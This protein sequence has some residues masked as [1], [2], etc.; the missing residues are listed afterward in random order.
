MRHRLLVIG[1]AVGV[2]LVS[3]VLVGLLV[4]TN[5]DYGRERVRRMA[6][7]AV[8]GAA[9]H[10]VVRLGRV[11]G[12]LLQG[13]TIANVSIRDSAGAPFLV[14]DSASLTYGLRALLLKRLD[15][16]NVRLVRPLIVLDRP[17]GDS[18]LWNYK[19]IFR[20]DTPK[21]LRDTTKRRF[22]DWIVFRD[23]TVVD[24]HMIIRSPWR[25]K[26]EYTGA[27]RDTAIV[28]AL[29]GK[30]R[31]KVVRRDDGFQKIVEFR[32]FTG[33]IP[34][35]RLKHPDTH[36]RRLEIAKL[37]TVALPFNPPAAVVNN[38]RGALDFT[39]DS[40]WF[41][42]VQATLP[43]SR[44]AA[45]GRYVF[46]TNEFDLLLRGEPVS[47]ADVRWVMPQVSSRGSG[48]LDFR[49]RWR[50]DT[51][52]YIAQKANLQVD[53]ARLGG[54]F[55][56]SLVGDSL[57]FHNTDVRFS[58]LDTH[59]IEQL[60]PAVRIPRHGTLTGTAKLDGP[61]GLMR[62]DGDVAFDDARY[63][64]SRV[65]AVGHVGTTGTGVRFRDLDVTLDPVRVAMANVFVRDFPLAGTM[66]GSAR[67]N[68]ATDARLDV[69]ADL[70]HDDNG[71][72]SRIAGNA[73]LRLGSR[74]WL[75][76]DARLMPLSL[77]EV[78]KFAPAAG[79]RGTAAGPV[80]ATG[81]LRNLRLDAQ[82]ALADGGRLDARGTVDLASAQ[83]GYD[84]TAQMRVFNA[85]SVTAR[86]P[87]TSLTATAFARG[88]G[89]DP[90]TMRAAVGASLATSTI[91][92]VAIDSAHVRAAIAG[93][94]LQVDSATVS[95][96]H[97]VVDLDGTFGLAAGRTGTLR[98]RASVDSLAALN[99]FFPVADTSTVAPR[100]RGYSR[101]VAQARADSAAVARATEIERLATG[102]AGPRLGPVPP[103][104]A[105]I[106]RDSTAGALTAAGTIRGGLQG[107]DLRGRAAAEGVVFRGSTL[108]RARVEYAWLGARTPKSSIAAGASLD[109]V[110]TSG[111]AMDSV[112][113]RGSYGR[114][115]GDVAVVI[116]QDTGEEYSVGG[117]FAV[118]PDHREVHLRQL[119]LR[120]DSTRWTAPHQSRIRWGAG[121][122]VVEK[123]ELRNGSNGRVFADGTIPPDRPG[124]LDVVIEN[125]QAADVAA[126]I[127]S[128]LAFRGLIT[129]T[130]RI[131]GTTAAPRFRAALGVANATY[132]GSAVPDIRATANYAAPRLT[133]H[134]EAA[135]SGRRIAVADGH[136]PMN[137]G[138]GGGPLMPDGPLEVDV[139]SDGLPLDLVS[140][141]TDV[142]ENV[143][144]RA[145]GVVTIRGTTRNPRTV[146]ALALLDGSLRV[147]PTG[148]QLNNVVASIR[149]LG[150]T[151]IIDSIAGRAGGR[152]VA[153]GGVG[154]R[155]LSQPSFDL[156][157][158]ADNA[159]VLNNDRG[160]VRADVGVT[161]K[162]P[163]NR[164]VVTGRVGV[165]NGVII[166][167]ESDNKQVISARDPA[168]YLVVDTARV[169]EDEVGVAAP[170]ALMA[171]L[172]VDVAVDVARDTWVRTSEANVEI[173]TPPDRGLRIN[174]DQRRRAIVLDGEVA[175]DRSEYEF[176]SKRFQ[177]RRGSAVFVGGNQ[178]DPN[179]QIT[180]EYEVRAAA[181]QAINIRVNIGGTLSRPR[182]ALDSDAQ[183]PLSQSD[184]LS[185]L[186][187]GRTSS[188]LLQFEGSSLSGGGGG[189][190]NNL[191]GAGAQLATQQLAAVALGVFVNEF[192]GQAARSL[193]A[194]YFNVTPADLYTEL[195]QGGE[196]SGF[197][198]GTEIEL[199]K[200][201]DPNTFVALQARLST[202]ASNPSDRAV[203]GIRMQR[204]LGKG[205]ALDMSFTPRYIPQPSSLERVA[206]RSTGVFGT[207]L[208]REWKF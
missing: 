150:D 123:L 74:P 89:F 207:F 68:G 168:L 7:S 44:A 153:K 78:G 183:P 137:L 27:R 54:D 14:A 186:A 167:P 200:Y 41:K 109:S 174:M 112:E 11:S 103:P 64:R 93:G 120:F 16:A 17:P 206:P 128:D 152:I 208:A 122:I 73:G 39:A 117:D 21:A 98:Y 61:P 145:F 45:D 59:L 176:L 106:R 195:A 4:F 126:L 13:F 104:P 111:F 157:L 107:F 42:D 148:M 131:E 79:L 185:Y 32:E 127:Q 125:F 82:L 188:S 10:G 46:D 28:D 187:F 191:A 60:F 76:V 97:T 24:G 193:G 178:L 108:R 26:G 162:G 55:A 49:L 165:R 181:S 90:A 3:A 52:T 170:S 19:A 80:R 114:S 99:R 53:S 18:A 156:V 130:A 166:I 169:D 116:Y 189:G 118:H 154:I 71:L 51:A 155:T 101:V 86:A 179:L 43:G 70:T 161:I 77:A 184:L 136:I 66:R 92:T 58:T 151:V 2:A 203:P 67:L 47:L 180:G 30:E 196:I 87:A 105:P 192:E 199:G 175:T 124:G 140:R 1:A 15:L 142:V 134:V 91:D 9:N 34:Y 201:T 25:P 94:M 8:Q 40:I 113:M 31:V 171:N 173:Y 197:F 84:L 147:V 23:V 190:S 159:R 65:V 85:R 6:Q 81:E 88:R 63:G 22:G 133:V 37:S 141:F 146:G 129:T 138:S 83:K 95:G 69:R 164:T 202:F 160:A 50:G 5:T 38:V 75:D 158:S 20:S 144:G 56:I 119:A 149:L 57:W 132:G 48:T 182:L 121:G 172:R 102:A 115:A 198:K 35:L 36:V 163:F 139:R 12:N 204:R 110:R 100:P 96:P 135:D 143:R 205:F 194:A 72:R 29:G 177:I 33:E 62:V